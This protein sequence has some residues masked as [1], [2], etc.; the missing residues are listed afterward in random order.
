M[1]VREGKFGIS[2][3][4]SLKFILYGKFNNKLIDSGNDLAPNKRQAI[5]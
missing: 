3:H 4:I 1:H 5:T 2:I